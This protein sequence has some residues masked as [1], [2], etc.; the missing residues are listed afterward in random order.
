MTVD[1]FPLY[2][3]RGTCAEV[4]DGDTMLVD[5]QLGFHVTRRIAIRIAD[6][7]CPEIRGTTKLAGIMAANAVRDMVARQLL[8][9]TTRKDA[10]SFDRWVADVWVP[11]ADGG[12]LSVAD[13][14]V[15]RGHAQ[16]VEG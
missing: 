9:I 3:Y 1:D 4:R 7:D 10:R 5:I 12:L 6:I 8:Y 11:G 16:R 15:D 14:M 2:F 13:I